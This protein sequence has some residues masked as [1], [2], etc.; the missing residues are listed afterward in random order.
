LPKVDHLNERGWSASRQ[1][2]AAPTLNLG[3][4]QRLNC[5]GGAQQQGRG[6][7]KSCEFVRRVSRMQ[8]RCAIRFVGA[9]MLFVYN[10]EANLVT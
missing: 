6:T 10:D 7:S 5:W 8:S 1:R 9:L 2:E 3:A 4:R